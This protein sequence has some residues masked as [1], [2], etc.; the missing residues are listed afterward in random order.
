M[1]AAPASVGAVL[2]TLTPLTPA[3][4]VLPAASVAVPLALWPAPS[5][6]V[7]AAAQFATPERLSA[8]MNITVTFP[9]FQPLPFAAGV[10]LAMIVGA[11]LSMLTVAGS[12]CLLP[13]LS[14]AVPVTSWPWP[15]V[16]TVCG[17]VQLL[18]PASASAQVN[19]TVTSPLFQP[20]PFASGDCVCLIVGAVLSMETC[21]VLAFSTLPAASTLQKRTV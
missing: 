11:V 16:V 21:T 12:A 14:S 8:Q 17:A 20:A 6:S 5:P 15:S 1:V 4:A 3:L 7:W 18:M 2:S 19:V 9:L 13:A 10:R